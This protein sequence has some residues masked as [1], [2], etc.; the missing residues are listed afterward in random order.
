MR[1]INEADEAGYPQ[2]DKVL[3]LPTMLVVSRQDYAT[4]A[5]MQLKRA[6][7]WVKNLRVETL[8][9]GHWIPLEKRDE[10]TGLLKGFADDVVTK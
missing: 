6:Q 4:R 9:G 5:D 3:T 1:G 2:G 7:E 10:L 8:D